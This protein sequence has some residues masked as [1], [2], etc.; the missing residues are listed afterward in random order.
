VTPLSPITTTEEAPY[1]ASTPAS[2]RLPLDPLLTLAVLGLAACSVITLRGATRNLLP[3]NPSYYTTRQTVYL[4]LGLLLMV[5]LS[6][7]DYSH[8]RRL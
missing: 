2:L 6:R 5:A 7:L 4:G 1:A 3:G 8:L